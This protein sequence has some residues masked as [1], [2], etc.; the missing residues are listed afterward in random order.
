MAES[1]SKTPVGKLHLNRKTFAELLRLDLSDV[2]F[3]SSS[4]S[5]QLSIF[6]EKLGADVPLRFELSYRDMDIDFGPDF[7][8]IS[9]RYM[10][11]IKV[12]PDGLNRMNLKTSHV[13]IYDEL[14]MTQSL[15]VELQDNILYAKIDK[16][17]LNIHERYGQK[18]LPKENNIDLTENEYKTFLNEFG[19]TLNFIKKYYNDVILRGGIDFPYDV[20]EF[21]TSVKFG[22]NAMF[23]LFETE[24]EYKMTPNHY[25]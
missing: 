17:A 3:T 18:S 16:L 20:P 21:Y 4:I 12:I 9:M 15:N 1:I 22:P 24:E 23:F 10:L 13:I 6:E 25:L 2:N 19:L 14:P 5:R 8:D 11:Q 7:H